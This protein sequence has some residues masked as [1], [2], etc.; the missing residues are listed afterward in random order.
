MADTITVTTDDGFEVSSNTETADEMLATMALDPAPVAVPTTD[1]EEEAEPTPAIAKP[2]V[3]AKLEAPK[4]DRRTREGRK[5]SIQQEIDELTT[6]KHQTKRELD[7]DQTKLTA[8][9]AELSAL[10]GRRAITQERRSPPVAAAAA[11]ATPAAADADDPE[12]TIDQFASEADPYTAWMRA[13]NKR[14]ARLEW[15][16]LENDK[17][18]RQ[19]TQ[20]IDT[21]RDERGRVLHE[22]IAEHEKTDPTWADTIDP[23]ILQAYPFMNLAKGEKA[24]YLNA[25]A[26][27]VWNPNYTKPIELMRYVSQPEIRQ[28]LSTL[29]QDEFYLEMGRI[30]ARLEAA[31]TSGPAPKSPPVITKAK[32]LIKPVSSSPVV[33][34][35]GADDEDDASEAAVNRHIRMGNQTDPSINPRA[36]RH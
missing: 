6:V 26:E 36:V 17:R 31:S 7:A 8:L 23:E 19:Q 24:N 2:A 33:S 22:R 32:P 10:E 30:L 35:D 1:D 5:L 20:H 4:V 11:T 15:R 16:R 9:R 25:I 14:D 13:V 3:E 34:D 21:L 28:R 27:I 29:P 18:E 12:P